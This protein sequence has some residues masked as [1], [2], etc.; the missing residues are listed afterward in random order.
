MNAGEPLLLTKSTCRQLW[1]VGQGDARGATVA[2]VETCTL[3][4]GVD[5]IS[6]HAC[7]GVV[8]KAHL[9]NNPMVRRPRGRR[10]VVT[11]IETLPTVAAEQ[12]RTL[13]HRG[14]NHTGRTAREHVGSSAGKNW[15]LRRTLVEEG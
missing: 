5:D 10:A 12:H 8:G 6:R 9:A 2:Q 7:R 3:N 4:N 1:F 13:H 15:K 14:K 11:V